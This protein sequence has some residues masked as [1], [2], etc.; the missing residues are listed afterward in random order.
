MSA[1]P[2]SSDSLGQ[3]S[4]AQG[5]SLQAH[6]GLPRR[7]LV[8]GLLLAMVA[9]LF[10]YGHTAWSVALIWERA[11]TYSHGFIVLPMVGYLIWRRR[12]ELAQLPVRPAWAVLPLLALAGL[13]WAMGQL[14]GVLGLTQF[15]LAAMLP[16]L[17]WLVAG[18]RIAR[19]ILFPLAFTFFAVP[20]GEFI[21]PIMM[22]GTASATVSAL[23]FTGIP[24]FR[25]GM[26]F[27]IP[28]GRWSVI[29]ACSGIRY[30]ISS[31]M[32]GSLFAY[33][34]YRS[35][36]K[37][38]VFAAVA[39]IVPVLANWM[40]A[41]LIVLM[42]HLTDNRLATGVDHIWFGWAIYGVVMGVV[43][44]LG[45]RWADPVPEAETSP[46]PATSAPRSALVALLA[47]VLMAAVWP[48]AAGLLPASKGAQA[49]L[50]PLVPVAG[51]TVTSAKP[52]DKFHPAY[53]GARAE[54]SQAFTSPDGRVGLSVQLFADQS[55]G[56]ELVN[57]ENTLVN[58]A[59]KRWYVA[60]QQDVAKTVR[61]APL[62]IVASRLNGHD[63]KLLV[64]QAYWVGGRW[65]TSNYLA[66]AYQLI[67]QLTGH[68]DVAALVAIYTPL[69]DDGQAAQHRLSTFI[70]AQGTGIESML[71][72]AAAAA[73]AEG[74]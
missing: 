16:L 33:L 53:Q 36:Y 23:R 17:V 2:I 62:P 50:D 41:Y 22:E 60:E 69:D 31:I 56:R 44:W 47:G 5:Q 30:L 1:H 24:V 20:F 18:T 37:R 46:A 14:S 32:V 59:D 51:W 74:S 35:A 8:V 68:G 6:A 67:S 70:D 7:V 4:G 19:A 3:S 48:S 27:V 55:Q 38:L 61:G 65:T 73:M 21:I 64:W 52:E 25:E 13:A 58:Q 40:R 42:A 49:K 28:S 9:L 43:Y 15:A 72:R 54:L 10:W 71:D 57:S 66:K 63:E 26:H 34:A 12:D 29:D 45:M 39:I 11:P